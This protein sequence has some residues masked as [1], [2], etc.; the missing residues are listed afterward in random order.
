V[1]RDALVAIGDPAQRALEEAMR[2]Q[3]TEPALRLHIPRT[4]S[5]FGNQRAADF[6]TEQL[7]REEVGLVRYK[8]LRGLGGMLKN[9]KLHVNRKVILAQM[10]RNLVEHLRLLASFAPLEKDVATRGKES[11]RLVLGLLEDKLRQSL[12]RAFRLLQIA[13]RGEDIRGVYLALQ[14]QDRRGR[15]DAMEFLD[16]LTSSAGGNLARESRELLRLVIDDLPASDK[17]KRATSQVPD[18]PA[19]YEAALLRLVES[20]D[21]YLAPLAAYHALELADDDVG[22][23]VEEALSRRPSLMRMDSVVL[24]RPAREAVQGGG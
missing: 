23:K 2:N 24:D 6:L 19:T 12:E 14:S 4:L 15:S 8:V 1:V 20:G 17:V 7:A 10:Q 9:R 22:E 18:Q 11:G 16:A 5:R 21:A 3:A 13:Y